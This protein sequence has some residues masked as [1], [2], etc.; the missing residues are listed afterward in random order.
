MFPKSIRFE[1]FSNFYPTMRS[2][3][4]LS[5]RKI[6][7]WFWAGKITKNHTYLLKI[8]PT[9]R[10]NFALSKAE[11]P[12][13]SSIFRNFRFFY[14]SYINSLAPK[15]PGKKSCHDFN[16]YFSGKKLKLEK[17]LQ[18]F[19]WSIDIGLKQCL[20][21]NLTSQFMTFMTGYNVISLW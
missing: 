8:T 16:Y 5:Y 17:N 18:I 12:Y 14:I 2:P 13:K 15:S 11:Q 3:F 19:P 20:K 7:A 10:D 21:K 6:F 9:K 4:S 1:K